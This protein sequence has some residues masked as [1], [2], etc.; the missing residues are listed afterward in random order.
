MQDLQLHIWQT[1]LSNEICGAFKVY[2]LQL[3]VPWKD[4]MQVLHFKI[5]IILHLSLSASSIKT[6]YSGHVVKK[7][8]I[9]ATGTFQQQNILCGK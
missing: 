9:I 5:N 3:S 8:Q 1:F 4:V 2:I 6:V 7:L